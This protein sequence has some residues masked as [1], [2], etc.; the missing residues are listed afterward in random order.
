M[1]EKKYTIYKFTFSDGKVYIGQTSQPV[2]DRWNHGEG[3]K[4]QEVYVPIILDGWNNVQKEIL[5]TGLTSEQADKLEKYYIK[6]FNSQVQGYNRTEGGKKATKTRSITPIISFERMIELEKTIIEKLPMLISNSPNKILTF[7]ELRELAETKPL[8]QVIYQS[9][10]LGEACWL[11]TAEK[12][13]NSIDVCLGS[14]DSYTL[15]YLAQWRIWSGNPDVITAISTPWLISTDV[16]EYNS[17]FIKDKKVIQFYKKYNRW[18]STQDTGF[19]ESI[20]N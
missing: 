19:R 5:H 10:M 18:P 7:K 20:Y 6:K 11:T 16:I 17:Y 9:H 13:A 4:G 14:T 1:E 15:D 3:Y 12:A 8:E 2:E